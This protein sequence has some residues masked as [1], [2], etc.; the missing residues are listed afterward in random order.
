MA[1]FSKSK[2]PAVQNLSALVGIPLWPLGLHGRDLRRPLF[3]QF[4]VVSVKPGREHRDKACYLCG[5][6]G[7]H[8][9]V[10]S[11]KVGSGLIV[12]RV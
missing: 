8:L 1:S 6:L 2:A 11:V 12:T 5:T 9:L 10:G 7:S 3:S 4:E